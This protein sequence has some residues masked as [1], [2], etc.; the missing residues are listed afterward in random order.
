MHLVRQ[1]KTDMLLDSQEK[2]L[3]NFATPKKESAVA[4]GALTP[5]QVKVG[6]KKVMSYQERLTWLRSSELGKLFGF[7]QQ[8]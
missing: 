4:S 1:E 6:T 5:S 3:A 2:K 8:A 7:T